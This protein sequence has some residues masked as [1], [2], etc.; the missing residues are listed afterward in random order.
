MAELR[1]LFAFM[2]ESKRKYVD[3]TKAVKVG[4]IEIA[5]WKVRANDFYSRLEKYRKIE[6]FSKKLSN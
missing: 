1:V 3:P 4:C 6:V 2:L 5:S